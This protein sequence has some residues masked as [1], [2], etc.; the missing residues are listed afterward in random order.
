MTTDGEFDVLK[1]TK[2]LE[3]ERIVRRTNVLRDDDISR[4]SLRIVD[5]YRRQRSCTHTA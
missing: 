5:R 1:R 4:E 3:T 2:G